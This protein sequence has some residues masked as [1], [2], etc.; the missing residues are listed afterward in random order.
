[1]QDGVDLVTWAIA[2]TEGGEIFVPKIPSY[3]ITDLAKAIG[4][5]CKHPIVGIRSGEK[6][7]E[8]MFTTTDSFNTVDVGKYF[9]ILPTTG[10]HSVQHYC[11]HNGR[12]LVPPG[13]AYNSGTNP[14]FLTVEQLRE[15]IRQN[16]D[17]NFKV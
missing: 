14:D 4:P 11:E 2:H 15:L 3:K 13:F 1:L 6:I 9:V 12:K 7:H 10:E 17:P 16:V 5:D 8:E